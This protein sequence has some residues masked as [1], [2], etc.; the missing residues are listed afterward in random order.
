MAKIIKRVIIVIAVCI[1][2]AMLG[3]AVFMGLFFSSHKLNAEKVFKMFILDPIPQTVRIIYGHGTWWQGYSV[4]AVFKTD[5]NT[6]EG[7]S[8]GYQLLPGCIDK[9]IYDSGVDAR[10]DRN[11]AFKEDLFSI[12]DLSCYY[13]RIDL[14]HGGDAYLFYDKDE[15]KAFFCASGG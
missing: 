13:R 9:H 2:A 7:L 5:Q 6:F 1:V 11:N 12:P 15:Q 8:S 14:R 10:K 4:A 3:M